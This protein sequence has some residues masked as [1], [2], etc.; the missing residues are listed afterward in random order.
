M[1]KNLS[2]GH[3]ACNF[4]N[5]R[6]TATGNGSAFAEVRAFGSSV[7]I[8]S[9]YWKPAICLSALTE[10]SVVRKCAAASN[11]IDDLGGAAQAHLRADQRIAG[12]PTC[13]PRP[14]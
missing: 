1:L 4:E 6:G 2:R 8:G 5:W 9:N 13:Q 11:A 14:G 12:H 7:L 3:L 10:W